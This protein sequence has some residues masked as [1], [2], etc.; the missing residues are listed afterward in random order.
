MTSKCGCCSRVTIWFISYSKEKIDQ[1]YGLLQTL[2]LGY[3]GGMFVLNTKGSSLPRLSL[4][5]SWL[6]A[7]WVSK[8]SF[9]NKEPLS[10]LPL[11]T[12]PN[13]LLATI[14]KLFNCFFPG[15]DEKTN[16]ELIILVGTAVIAMFFWLLLVIILRTVKRVMKLLSLCPISINLAWQMKTDWHSFV[17]FLA[18]SL[19]QQP[20]FS[21]SIP[22]HS[23]LELEANKM[24]AF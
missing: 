1:Q 23:C 15:T 18:L 10:V 16:L 5:L 9:L 11:M 17:L 14:Y 22:S 8:F 24:F 4:S 3:D 12:Y 6:I 7:S 20:H 2:H 13:R 21:P 19:N